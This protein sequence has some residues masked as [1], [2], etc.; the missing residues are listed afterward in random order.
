MT[1]PKPFTVYEH[2]KGGRYIVICVAKRADDSSARDV[3]YY[4]LMHNEFWTRPLEEWNEP[5]AFH[6]D[7]CRCEAENCA[8]VVEQKL[9]F[10]EVT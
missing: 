9:R 10:K 4:S 8:L 1:E 6:A 7:G 3:I 5:V 2:F